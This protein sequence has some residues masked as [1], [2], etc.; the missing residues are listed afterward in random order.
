MRESQEH[1]LIIHLETLIDVDAATSLLPCDA[2]A[3]SNSNNNRDDPRTQ[4][5]VQRKRKSLVHPVAAA[6]AVMRK[7]EEMEGRVAAAVGAV[8][9][10]TTSL[11]CLE[12]RLNVLLLI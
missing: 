10:M 3:K 4:A 9:L 6:Q 8:A 12:R 11:T 5:V 7:M 2:I 1:P